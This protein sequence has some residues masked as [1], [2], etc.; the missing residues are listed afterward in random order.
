MKIIIILAITGVVAACVFST[1]KISKNKQI[2]KENPKIKPEKKL[3]YFRELPD[4]TATPLE[5]VF[6][7]NKGYNQMS[8]SQVFLLPVEVLHTSLN[9]HFFWHWH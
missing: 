4:K 1:I 3:D 5:A 2:L 8:L 9:L 7:L 6:I